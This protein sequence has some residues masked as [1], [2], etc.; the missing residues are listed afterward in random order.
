VQESTGYG[1]YGSAAMNRSGRFV[2]AWMDTRSG[3]SDVYCQAF[4][5]DGT[6]IGNNILANLDPP[7]RYHGY[8]SCAIDE[9]GR[10]VV[11]WEDMRDEAYDVYLQWFDSTG[12]MIRGNER[13]NDNLAPGAAY[14]PSCAFAPNGRLAVEFNDERDFP[15]NPQIYCQRFGPD[16]A[17]ISFNKMVNEPKLFPNN[18]HWTVGQSIAA[19]DDVLA[20]AWTDNRRHKGF[21]IN[22]KLTD[23]DLIG[24]S[25]RSSAGSRSAGLPSV[26]RRNGRL[27]IGLHS[28]GPV[29][30][31]YDATGRQVRQALAA[32]RSGFDL[33]G[34]GAGTYFVV[35]RNGT[36]YD[37]RK[38]VIE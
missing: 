20:F 36:A 8:P 7:G 18:S 16:G 25:E 1:E 33:T 15:G 34:V 6:R 38:V 30:W 21:D 24:V 9:Q 14:S 12:A 37:C 35:A 13:V 5:A 4:R 17:R 28:S 10:F 19:S 23:W 2:T 31:L 29:V 22:A 26:V 32:D 27:A 11:A 3:T